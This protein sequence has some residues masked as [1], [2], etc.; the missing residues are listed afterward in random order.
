[1][2]RTARRGNPPAFGIDRRNMIRNSPAAAHLRWAMKQVGP[3]VVMTLAIYVLM[4][5]ATQA[6]M[7]HNSLLHY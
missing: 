1:M 4:F 7:F 2:T 3:V 5:L 6:A